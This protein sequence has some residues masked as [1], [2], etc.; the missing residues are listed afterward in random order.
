MCELI[1]SFYIMETR[2]TKLDITDNNFKRAAMNMA[3]NVI[4]DMETVKFREDFIRHLDSALY[5][6]TELKKNYLFERES[7]DA[8]N[9]KPE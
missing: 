9:S 4:A 6:F 1:G 2:N 7:L 8:G 3:Q 5:N